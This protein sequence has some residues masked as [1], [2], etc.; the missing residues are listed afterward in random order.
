[1]AQ[2]LV[3]LLL[4]H[5]RLALVRVSHRVPAA[6]HQQV[7]V[8]EPE[9]GVRGSEIRSFDGQP[10]KLTNSGKRGVYTYTVHNILPM[11][12]TR[13]TGMELDSQLLGLL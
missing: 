11:M 2:R 6:P 10:L 12:Q 8:G 9:G 1:M 5:H 4:R 3:S 7:S 13:P